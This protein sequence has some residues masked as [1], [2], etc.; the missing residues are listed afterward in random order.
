MYQ[1]NIDLDG[2]CF[3]IELRLKDRH[4]GRDLVPVYCMIVR[5][6]R[7]VFSALYDDVQKGILNVASYDAMHATISKSGM[8]LT[9]RAFKRAVAESFQRY[10]EAIRYPKIWVDKPKNWSR[11]NSPWA[12]T[13]NPSWSREYL[14]TWQESHNSDRPEVYPLGASKKLQGQPDAHPTTPDHHSNQEEPA[15]SREQAFR[16]WMLKAL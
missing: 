10:G 9:P 14:G 1:L 5:S 6:E 4:R 12:R 11:D 15:P 8:Q 2:D 7:E 13:V 16:N 3:R